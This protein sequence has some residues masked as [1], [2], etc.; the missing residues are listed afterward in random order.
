MT[1]CLHIILVQG[2]YSILTIILA[3]LLNLVIIWILQKYFVKTQYVGIRRTRNWNHFIVLDFI[4][5]FHAKP[6]GNEMILLLILAKNHLI[7][8]VLGE[9]LAR[10]K[11]NCTE[12][13][14]EYRRDECISI[15]FMH[16]SCSYW[17]R[18][19]LPFLL[20]VTSP[21]SSHFFAGFLEGLPS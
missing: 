19:I 4:T 15:S 16:F 11:C 6:W 2:Y 18:V 9:D 5:S 7:L 3:S 8:K 14:R 13:G 17:R 1:K 21:R 10:S 12:D 20:C